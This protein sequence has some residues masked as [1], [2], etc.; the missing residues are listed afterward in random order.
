MNLYYIKWLMFTKNNNIKIRKYE[1]DRKTNAYTRWNNCSF[2]KF[3]TNY[4]EELCDLLKTL[5]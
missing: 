1:V 3:A 4:K 2:K 5:I